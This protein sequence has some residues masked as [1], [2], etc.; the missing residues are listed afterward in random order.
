M[1]CPPGSQ[2][3]ENTIECEK[4]YPPFNA[5]QC[6]PEAPVWNPQLLGCFKCNTSTPYYDVNL[7]ICTNCPANTTYSP[8]TNECVNK[9]CQ[10]D[11]VYNTWTQ[12]CEA[13]KVSS[14]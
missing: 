3:N 6:P 2:F 5:S 10:S 7:G 11:Q 9:N 12:Q 14:N 8:S 13:K 1:I 4:V